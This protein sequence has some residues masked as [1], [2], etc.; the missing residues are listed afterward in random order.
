MCH[1]VPFNNGWVRE[2]QQYDEES[3]MFLGGILFWFRT[4]LRYVN[5]TLTAKQNLYSIIAPCVVSL[6]RKG[7]LYFSSIVLAL[8]SQGQIWPIWPPVKLR[9]YLGRHFHWFA[10]KR[11][12]LVNPFQSCSH[13]PTT[14]VEFRRPWKNGIG[15]RRTKSTTYNDVSLKL[16]PMEDIHAI[17]F[18]DLVFQYGVQMFII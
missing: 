5:R 10:T 17:R 2:R 3:V 15:N 12:P 11:T 18:C 8:T 13:L 14:I 4:G 9:C 7:I 6:A 16:T 1:G